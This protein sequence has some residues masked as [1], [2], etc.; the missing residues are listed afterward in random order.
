MQL[1]QTEAAARENEPARHAE[2]T[3]AP[4][5]DE[6]LPAR[7][8]LQPGAPFCEY[9]PAAQLPQTEAAAGEKVPAVQSVHAALPMVFLYEPAPHC[10]QATLFCPVNPALHE[11]LLESSQQA[12]QSSL[13]QCEGHKTVQS[14]K[15][16]FLRNSY[17]LWGHEDKSVFVLQLFVVRCYYSVFRPSSGVCLAKGL[18]RRESHYDRGA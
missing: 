7:Q 2:Q 10:V 16:G 3:E 8:L 12:P 9:V 4:T 5:L 6:N 1:L 13:H 14:A 11:Q 18:S 17:D 15:P